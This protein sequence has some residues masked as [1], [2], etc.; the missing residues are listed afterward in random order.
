MAGFRFDSPEMKEWRLA[1]KRE[2]EA[3]RDREAQEWAKRK[4]RLQQQIRS[5]P[6]FDKSALTNILLSLKKLVFEYDSKQMR[7]PLDLERV[8]LDFLCQS[9]QAGAFS[10]PEWLGWRTRLADRP[11][12]SNA[13]LF[14]TNYAPS[15]YGVYGRPQPSPRAEISVEIVIDALDYFITHCDTNISSQQT[16][17]PDSAA[18][19]LVMVSQ[20]RDHH[21]EVLQAL[22]ELKALDS[23]TRKPTSEITR[24]ALGRDADPGLL[25]RPISELR[26]LGLV[27]TKEG[28]SGGAWLTSN[29]KEKAIKISKL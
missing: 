2:G 15:P 7:N 29:G 13:V 8:A 19:P 26:K 17:S 6:S 18:L 11:H 16:I 24:V 10:G 4:E 14:F 1:S 23:K 21:D 3:R 20:P 22:L 27:A 25:K 12:I 28:R 5:T 9:I